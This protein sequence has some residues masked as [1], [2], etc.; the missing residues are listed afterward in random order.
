[1]RPELDERVKRTTFGKAISTDI[2]R[3]KGFV[4]AGLEEFSTVNKEDYLLLIESFVKEARS[5]V[6]SFDR[7]IKRGQGES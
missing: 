3:L 7:E 1:M 2:A 4:D 6:Y 5:L